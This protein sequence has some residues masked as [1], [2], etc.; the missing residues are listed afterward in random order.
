MAD[1]FISYSTQEAQW[2]CELRDLLTRM[3]REVWMAPESIPVGS[4]YADQIPLAI[5]GSRSLALVLTPH[6]DASIWVQKEVGLALSNTV[7]VIPLRPD[8]HKPSGAMEFFLSDVQIRDVDSPEDAA[9]VVLR[10]LGDTTLDEKNAPSDPIRSYLEHESSAPD[11]ESIFIPVSVLPDAAGQRG[12]LGRSLIGS[13]RPSPARPEPLSPETLVTKGG[14]FLVVGEAGSGKTTFLRRLFRQACAAARN[15]KTVALPLLVD[16]PSLAGNGVRELCV[17]A[18]SKT[19]LEQFD[20]SSVASQIA[21]RGVAIFVDGLDECR[22][23]D[24]RAEMLEALGAL[25]SSVTV[26][27]IVAT[28]R[29]SEEIAPAGLSI[30]RLAPF[31]RQEQIDFLDRY[32]SALGIGLNGASLLDALS[33]DISA[34]ASRPLFLAL[35]VTSVAYRGELPETADELFDDYLNVLLDG[36]CAEEALMVERVLCEVAFWCVRESRITVPLE[37]ISEICERETSDQE[38]AELLRRS[39]LES[40]VLTPARGGARFAH[41]TLM[42]HLA[43]NYAA[44]IYNF[45]PSHSMAQYFLRNP[46][47]IELMVSSGRVMPTDCVAELGAG[48]G[49]VARHIPRAQS[50]TLVELDERLATILRNDFSER[51]DVTVHQG[52]AIAWLAEHDVDVIFSNLPFFLTDELLDVFAE[53][54]FRTALVAMPPEHSLDDWKDRLRFTDVEVNEGS[55][56]FPPQPVAS[57]VVRVTPR[58]G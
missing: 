2:A 41:L 51:P 54:D 9:V 24:A 42:D 46:E 17:R 16:A 26:R 13:I 25:A 15:N 22:R 50:L 31:T 28:S 57:K 36:S 35:L 20:F 5:K 39:V 47:K 43:R 10:A 21:E 44:S 1:V 30:L 56:Y 11:E 48:I 12:M 32:T 6:A 3:G 29:P 18:L 37:K 52:D 8:G 34:L 23:A 49:S 33:D 19:A 40:G 53:K 27:A 45:E 7:V 55:D 4:S 58:R 14:L 38:A